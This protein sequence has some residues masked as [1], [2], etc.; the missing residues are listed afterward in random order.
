MARDPHIFQIGSTNYTTR[1]YCQSKGLHD[2]Y[3]IKKIQWR[4]NTYI[5][6][7]T[8]QETTK[9]LTTLV[10]NTTRQTNKE[11]YVVTPSGRRY[12]KKCNQYHEPSTTCQDAQK[13]PLSDGRESPHTPLQDLI[14]AQTGSTPLL[15]DGIRPW[16]GTKKE[17]EIAQQQKE[18]REAATRKMITQ[19]HNGET[20]TKELDQR[21]LLK[22]TR[23]M[24]HN[25]KWLNE[26]GILPNAED[27][28]KA[29]KPDSC[30]NWAYDPLLNDID[31]KHAVKQYALAIQ[32][33]DV[34]TYELDQLK[35]LID[36]LQLELEEAQKTLNEWHTKTINIL[37]TMNY[38]LQKWIGS[39]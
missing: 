27:I 24:E 28:Q 1:E 21:E 38:K 9:E 34:K 31:Y 12:H 26:A 7:H 8:I 25:Q 18:A 33:V 39:E 14:D 20:E 23:W 2:N 16:Q 5:R 3:E 10:A 4:I 15:L 36:P 32:R 37:N 13:D 29:N 22:Q 30:G 11:I 17:R 19:Q 35:V 6:T